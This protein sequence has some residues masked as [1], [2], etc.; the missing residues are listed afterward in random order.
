MDNPGDPWWVSVVAVVIGVWQGVWLTRRYADRQSRADWGRELVKDLL[1]A[2]ADF[3]GYLRD[4]T[5]ARA[6]ASQA[7]MPPVD[8]VY[9]QR[10]RLI[11]V[12][13]RASHLHSDDS[14]LATIEERLWSLGSALTTDWA[15]G[16]SLT[17]SE[18][19]E[20]K[21]AQI[22]ADFNGLRPEFMAIAKSIEQ[23]IERPSGLSWKGWR[24]RA[25]RR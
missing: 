24:P 11:A 3:E 10:D 25:G 21:R 14:A 16:R 19:R 12:L 15:F 2:E 22:M 7:G 5:A 1:S 9:R 18:G 4:Y 20:R 17:D 6:A 13:R 8:M 23:S